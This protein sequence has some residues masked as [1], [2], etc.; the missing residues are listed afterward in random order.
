MS[1]GTTTSHEFRIR[2]ADT[3][4]ITIDTSQRV[5]IGTSSP[6]ALLHCDYTGTRVGST[7]GHI[8][9]TV[10][11]DASDYTLFKV[12]NFQGATESVKLFVQGDGKVGVGTTSP[13]FL[14]DRTRPHRLQRQIRH[15]E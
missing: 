5:G 13:G 3:D 12:S 1:I 14:L 7:I 11:G 2:T 6:S 10:H 15:R 9:T 8:A 4:A